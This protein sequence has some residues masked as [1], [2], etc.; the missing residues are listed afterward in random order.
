MTNK[1]DNEPVIDTRTI[2]DIPKDKRPKYGGRAKGTPNKKTSEIRACIHDLVTDNMDNIQGW[3]DSV[4]KEDPAKAINIFI[5]LAEYVLPK[6]SKIDMSN[7]KK[8]GNVNVTIT[9]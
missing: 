7:G 9:K 2:E 8:A 3:L 1:P 4:A 6:L 5:N